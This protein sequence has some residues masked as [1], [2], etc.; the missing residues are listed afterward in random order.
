MVITYRV[1]YS[2]DNNTSIVWANNLDNTDEVNAAVFQMK[3]HFGEN[4]ILN[5]KV[6]KVFT[7]SCV[8]FNSDY[9]EV[10]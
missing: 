9:R 3:A 6:F 1:E 10:L 8:V 2:I 7:E 5:Y 4:K